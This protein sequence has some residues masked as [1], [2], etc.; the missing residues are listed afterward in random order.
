MNHKGKSGKEGL[1]KTDFE[2]RIESGF[3]RHAALDA[4]AIPEK[5][6]MVWLPGGIVDSREEKEAAKDAAC[7]A[8]GV[9]EVE[10]KLSI[11]WM[12]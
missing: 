2:L 10:N 8:L 5:P 1:N 4:K 7:S 11:M 9:I 12:N 6:M 3:K